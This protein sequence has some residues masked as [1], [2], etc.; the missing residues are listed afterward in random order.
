MTSLTDRATLAGR[1]VGL[2]AGATRAAMLAAAGTLVTRI[3]D[4]EGEF[5]VTARS[6]LL[7]CR[8]PR[9]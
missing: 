9:R 2:P 5:A 3:I 8:S 6:G 7:I 4:R 1:E